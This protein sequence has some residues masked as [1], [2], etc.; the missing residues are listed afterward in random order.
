MFRR[1]TRRRNWCE[2]ISYPFYAVLTGDIIGSRRWNAQ[3]RPELFDALRTVAQ[4]LQT[5]S[6]PL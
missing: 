5:N 2:W 1:S 6:Q 4:Q 3:R